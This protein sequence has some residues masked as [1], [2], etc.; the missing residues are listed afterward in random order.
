MDVSILPL[1]KIFALDVQFRVPLYQRPYVWDRDR[2]WEPLWDDVAALAERYLSTDRQVMH[3]FLGAIVVRQQPTP[4]GTLEVRDVIDGQQRLTTLQLLGDAVEETIREDDGPAIESKRLR[5]LVLN[6]TDLFSDDDRFKVWPTSSDQPTFRRVMIDHDKVPADL[7]DKPIARAHAYFKSAARAWAQDSDS[8]NSTAERYAALVK[9]ISYGLHLVVIDLSEADNAQAIFETLNARGTPLLAS[10]LVKNHLLNEAQVLGL[11]VYSLHSE[12]WQQFEDDWWRN[13]VTLGRTSW[14]R[15]DAFL[16][17]WLGMSLTRE[18]STQRL[19]DEYRDLLRSR[20]LTVEQVASNIS[21]FARVFQSLEEHSF[22]GAA[23]AEFFYRWKTTQLR[24]MTPLLL[25]LFSEASE[26][27]DS[28]RLEVLELLE[29]WF[30]R[31]MICGWRTHGYQN[32]LHPLLRE[33]KKHRGE[34]VVQVVRDTLVNA[35]AVNTAWPDDNA[36]YDAVR[37]RPMYQYI[38]RARLRLILEAVEDR[39]SSLEGK[40]ESRCPKNLT[41]EHLLPVSWSENDWP[42]VGSVQSR[43]ERRVLLH[44]LGNLTLVNDKLNPAL[45]NSPW[46]EKRT[47]LATHSNLHLNKVLAN[48]AVVSDGHTWYT[49]WNDDTILER[50][51]WL[52]GHMCEIWSR[53]S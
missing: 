19:F 46:T 51:E 13:E 30:M 36:V 20:S 6:D 44:T 27:D 31:R 12:H 15:V 40:S 52:A 21:T 50:G 3:H 43:E 7:V 11:D 29:S 53:P 39:L 16:F 47:G 41:I 9:A 49:E 38:S 10:D 18:V 22:G 32:F 45:S 2:Q 26:I 28:S 25:W 34:E 37:Q 48:P 14:P 23:L 5:K 24:V 35:D 4:V 1:Q 33:V 8:S 17:Y 42:Y